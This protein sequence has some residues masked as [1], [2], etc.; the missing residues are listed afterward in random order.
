MGQTSCW[1]HSDVYVTNDGKSDTV[2]ISKNRKQQ[3]QEEGLTILSSPL[4]HYH[5]KKHRMV[6]GH[7][8]ELFEVC[9]QNL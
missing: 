5:C 1:S 7:F 8:V 6:R 4:P 9:S 2:S 3:E